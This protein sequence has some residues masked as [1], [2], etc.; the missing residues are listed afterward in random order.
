MAGVS[1]MEPGLAARFPEIPHL[2]LEG[3]DNGVDEFFFPREDLLFCQPQPFVGALT[4][5][6][7]RLILLP[8]R[9]A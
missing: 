1:G 4:V 7:Q 6:I 5:I 2:F 8:S 9:C 3:V